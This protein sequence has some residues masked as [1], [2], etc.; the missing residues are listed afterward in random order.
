[1]KSIPLLFVFF[2]PLLLFSQNWEAVGRLD[3]P[4]LFRVH[5]IIKYNGEFIIGGEF[6][7][8]NIGIDR[9]AILRNGNWE[10][11]GS[12]L[13]Q[14]RPIWNW[15]MGVHLLEQY[16][17]QLIAGGYFYNLHRM[18]HLVKWNG[19][20]WTQ[21][22]DS[23][24]AGPGVN[25][26]VYF[27][28]DL[29]LAGEANLSA[30]P[31]IYDGCVMKWD[32]VHL[33]PLGENLLNIADNFGSGVHTLAA[34]KDKLYAGGEFSI[35]RL[36]VPP[37]KHYV[38]AWNGHKW[39]SLPE[40]LNGRVSAMAWFQGELYVGGEFT[41]AGN[42]PVGKLVKWNGKEW[43]DPGIEITDDILTM[44]VYDRKLYVGGGILG[45]VNGD[46]LGPAIFSYDGQNW[47]VAASNVSSVNKL[48]VIDSV[49]YAI[50]HFYSINGVRVNCIASYR[51]PAVS[52]EHSPP[53]PSIKTYPTPVIDDFFVEISP[54]SQFKNGKIKLT[55]MLGKEVFSE[56]FS[57]SQKHFDLQYLPAGTYILELSWSN[58]YYNSLIYKH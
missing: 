13:Q 30:S 38:A 42:R 3:S 58:Y 33:Y 36:R 9:V 5:D 39:D 22:S 17:G 44:V 24:G 20:D 51:S 10:Q 35:I 37:F 4:V 26:S 32:G 46:T 8:A 25:S 12:G 57:S 2:I 49:L 48:R 14:Y 29:Y 19:N 43:L 56:K 18:A 54:F 52:I 7:S 31:Y 16:N 50:G 11:M 41:K 1:M 15:E 45:I 28:G 55:D 21:F 53:N 40:R 23:A 27:N 34:S 47:E 6:D